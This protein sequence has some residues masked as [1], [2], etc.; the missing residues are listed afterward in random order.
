[1]TGEKTQLTLPWPPSTNTTWRRV[2][3][4]TILSKP[5]RLYRLAVRSI[6]VAAR[7]ASLP[8]AGPQDIKVTLYPPTLA[9]RDEDN[10]AGKSLFDALTGAGV[11]H[12]DSQVRRKLVE[13]GPVV[14]GGQVIVEIRPLVETGRSAA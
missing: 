3:R 6:V 10:F 7:L 1:M 5:A 9:R 4:R 12:D 8:L 13:W 11:W 2:G 14:K